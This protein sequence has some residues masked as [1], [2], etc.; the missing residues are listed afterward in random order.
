MLNMS[1]EMLVASML[2]LPTK[3]LLGNCIDMDAKY[4]LQISEINASDSISEADK[5]AQVIE[6]QNEHMQAK[7]EFLKNFD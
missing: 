2:T 5:A 3:F 6:I 7:V 1:F 4:T